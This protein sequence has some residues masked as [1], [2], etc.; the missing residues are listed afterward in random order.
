VKSPSVSVVQQRMPAAGRS[1]YDALSGGSVLTWIVS[2]VVVAGFLNPMLRRDWSDDLT[3]YRVVVVPVLLVLFLFGR[4]SPI[5]WRLVLVFPAI[6]AGYSLGC[7]IANDHLT[8]STLSYLANLVLGCWF[9]ALCAWLRM[10]P[11]GDKLRPLVICWFWGLVTLAIA[12]WCFDFGLGVTP[13]IGGAVDLY[14]GQPNEASLAIGAGGIACWEFLR[15]N[16]WRVLGLIGA[17]LAA[18]VNGSRGVLVSLFLFATI[19]AIAWAV[20][21]K[22]KGRFAR[23]LA[24]GVALGAV[25]MT[26]DDSVMIEGFWTRPASLYEFAIEPVEALFGG[27]SEVYSTAVR[28]KLIHAGLHMLI[29]TWG[30]GI[31]PGAFALYGFELTSGVAASMHVF[32]IERVV[33][34]GWLGLLAIGLWLRLIPSRRA[35]PGWA[36]GLC[37]LSLT[38]ASSSAPITNY[39]FIAVA[40]LVTRTTQ[41]ARGPTDDRRVIQLGRATP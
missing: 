17:T 19:A 35:I 30:F 31:G 29:D 12:Q 13:H 8:W 24:A 23:L 9:M 25:A 40:V 18:W 3:L 28:A 41:S 14:F 4:I 32:P 1:R 27:E 6:A 20:D 36:L 15:R 37:V 26:L 16:A 21:S 2:S 11:N 34:L 22:G 10:R 39:Y 38:L 5:E 33:E 7:L